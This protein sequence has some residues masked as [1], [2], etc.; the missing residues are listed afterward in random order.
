[1]KITI[2]QVEGTPE[3]CTKLIDTLRIDS[4]MELT[5]VINDGIKAGRVEIRDK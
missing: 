4:V 1:M 5:K 3:E 2:A